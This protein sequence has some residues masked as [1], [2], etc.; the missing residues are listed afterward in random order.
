MQFEDKIIANILYDEE[1]AFKI[2]PYTKTD[3]FDQD[4]KIVVDEIVK[5]FTE[6][7]AIPT[8]DELIIEVSNRRLPRYSNSI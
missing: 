3:Y 2:L 1:Y 8:K 5:F 7:G 6:Y 4:Y